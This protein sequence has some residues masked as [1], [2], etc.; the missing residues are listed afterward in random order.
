MSQSAD[1]ASPLHKDAQIQHIAAI[2]TPRGVCARFI[3]SG[4]CLC[5]GQT[6]SNAEI[7]SLGA[8]V[9]ALMDQVDLIC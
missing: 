4:A 2:S 1:P 6:S 7:A 3:L 9:T 8:E 5:M